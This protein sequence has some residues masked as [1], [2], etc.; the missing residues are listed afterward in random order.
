[1]I[2]IINE[3]L[4]KKEIDKLYDIL[5]SSD[6]YL[7]GIENHINDRN[8]RRWSLSKQIKKE[9]KDIDFFNEILDKILNLSI[10]N[11]EYDCYRNIINAY[12]YS[13]VLSIHDDGVTNGFKNITALIYGNNNWDANWGSETVF[14]DKIGS[15][16]EII[17]SI[18]PKPGR[19]VLFD[20]NIP[21]TG[22]VPSSMFPNYRYS[23]VYNLKLKTPKK[24]G[25]I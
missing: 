5:W 19:L 10:L 6:L 9:D 17:K 2:E 20:A 18:L 13:D 15:D 22:R 12:K 25:L 24:T 4:N 8:D 11:N 23:L 14:F 3:F 1:M 7:I 16:A 21:H